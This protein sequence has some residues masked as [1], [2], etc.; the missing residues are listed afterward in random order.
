MESA[1]LFSGKQF[2]GIQNA[3]W[4]KNV[5]DSFLKGQFP[6]GKSNVHIVF[7]HPADAVFSAQ[8][9]AQR[10]TNFKNFTDG[11]RQFIVPGF[12]RKVP[13]DDVHMQ[14]SVACMA[15]AHA[16]KT[17]SVSDLLHGS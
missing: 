15:V 17:I 5:F 14:V 13:P 2:T 1:F 3:G 11:F 10:N 6:F 9:S 7:L 16:L 8:C 4:I 12:L